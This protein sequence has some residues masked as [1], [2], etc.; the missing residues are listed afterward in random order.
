MSGCCLSPS[1]TEFFP[2]VILLSSHSF[3][4]LRRLLVILL[5]SATFN[6]VNTVGETCIHKC[7]HVR[8]ML[9]KC[10]LASVLT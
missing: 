7:A 10:P 9:T 6:R 2:L 5:P 4:R 1:G 8:F 3:D